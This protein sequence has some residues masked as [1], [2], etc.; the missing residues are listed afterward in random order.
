MSVKC[1]VV[2]DAMEK[3]APKQLAESWDNIGLLIG[4]PSQNVT[5]ILITLDITQA[6]VDQ[7]LQDGVDMIIAHHPI[8]FKPLKRI[9]TDTPHGKII[10]SLLQGNIAV[11]AAHTNLDSA[12]GGVNDILATALHM[13]HTEPLEGSYNEKL[14]KLTVFV[15]QTHIEVVRS[16]I[17]KVGAGHI[18]NYSHCTFTSQGTGSFLPMDDAKPFIGQPGILEYVEEMRLE[19]VVPDALRRQVVKAMLKAHPYEEVA[20]DIIELMNVG[21]TRGLGRVGKLATPIS[22]SDFIGQ[23]KLALGLDYVTVIGP[24]DKVIKKVAVCGG[25][26]ASLIHK[27]VF[28]GADVLVT[29][30][31][32]Y[33]EAQD[34][35]AAGIAIIDAGH[36]ATEQPVI[37]YVAEYLGRYDKWAIDIQV[38]TVNRDVFSVR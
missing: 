1:Q 25:S 34:A 21:P 37:R 31:V 8:L 35:L 6:V 11:Y 19:T 24:L 33:H 22:F 30:D 32:K 3:L 7:A 20:Y 9:R 29:G 26:G 14:Y 36:F 12:V 38:D 2:M 10:M 17:T 27:A 23:V 28:A 13:N 15:P 18:G 4:S 16:A 5:K